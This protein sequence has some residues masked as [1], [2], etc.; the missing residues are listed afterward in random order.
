MSTVSMTT[1]SR[2]S[3]LRNNIIMRTCFSLLCRHSCTLFIIAF[4]FGFE[5]SSY[6]VIESDEEVSVC[7]TGD[8][9][10]GSEM[11]TLSLTSII[12]T[13]QGIYMYIVLM[14]MAHILLIILFMQNSCPIMQASYHIN[15]SGCR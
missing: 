7:V 10:D 6:S 15:Y 13:S 8:R 1:Q 11:Y 9:G 12:V 5:Q 14:V 4:R 3:H 2:V